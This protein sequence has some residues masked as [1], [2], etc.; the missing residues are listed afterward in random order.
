MDNLEYTSVQE[1]MGQLAVV[2]LHVNIR[3]VDVSS[4]TSRARFSAG[5]SITHNLAISINT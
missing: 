2:F 3:F 1:I 5:N 4:C